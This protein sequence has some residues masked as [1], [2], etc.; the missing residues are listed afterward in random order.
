VQ[1]RDKC[2]IKKTKSVLNHFNYV[3]CGVEILSMSKRIMNEVMCLAEDLDLTMYYQDTDSIHIQ[4]NQ[5][6]ILADKFKQKYG[7]ELIGKGLGNF[8]CDFSM[9]HSKSDVYAVES[10]FIS[11]KVYLDVLESRD[12]NNNKLYAYHTR[13]KAVPTSCIEYTAKSLNT[14]ILQLYDDL[15]N[16]KTIEFDL[17]ENGDKCSFKIEDYEHIS[18]RSEFSRKLKFN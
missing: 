9:K 7:R 5:V 16:G 6:A 17:L 3:H 1:I 14:S 8:H 11:K 10:Y 12:E 13:M 18:S 2:Y 15:F 4:R